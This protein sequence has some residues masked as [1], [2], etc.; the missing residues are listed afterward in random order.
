V[1]RSQRFSA[2]HPA[3]LVCSWLASSGCGG[4]SP[5]AP[6]RVATTPA[7]PTTPQTTLA[8]VSG[9]TGAP[10]GG[11][12]I[13]INGVEHSSGADGRLTTTASG[14][15]V[16]I[17]AAGFYTRL[18]SLARA[19]DG[20]LTLWPI[21]SPTGMDQ[22]FTAELVYTNSG[23]GVIEPGIGDQRLARWAPG[24][25]RIEVVYLGPDDNPA[26]REFNGQMLGV[27]QRAI[28]V[29]NG[30]LGG[31]LVYSPLA[32]G[33]DQPGTGRVRIRWFEDFSYCKEFGSW[34]L[35]SY[36]EWPSVRNVT[37]TY[38]AGAAA[39]HLGTAVHELGHSLGLNHSS[40][41][42]DVMNASGYGE[43]EVPSRREALAIALMYQRLPG[44]LFP[45]ND[46]QASTSSESSGPVE[47]L[48][49]R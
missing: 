36:R 9:E 18:T 48:C 31:R 40:N 4:G 21:T 27:L 10:V 39:R 5:A 24:T 29:I 26:Y 6:T 16:E 41:R 33:S 43:V 38:C 34:A 15:L 1:K 7:T 19:E 49:R 22:H 23:V 12:S 8:I 32:E 2:V 28:D 13:V 25:S 44:N 14:G 3:F 37:I 42:R 20:R 46:R 11:A 45:D 30:T 47:I 17:G 35:T